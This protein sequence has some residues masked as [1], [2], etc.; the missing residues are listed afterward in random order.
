M[1][2]K[3]KMNKVPYVRCEDCS[4]CLRQEIDGRYYCIAYDEYLFDVKA[5]PSKQCEKYTE[6]NHR[7]AS[8]FKSIGSLINISVRDISDNAEVSEIKKSL[9]VSDE[10]MKKPFNI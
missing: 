4:N 3:E 1:T 10:V 2:E 8:G 6:I 7:V 5:A 9:D